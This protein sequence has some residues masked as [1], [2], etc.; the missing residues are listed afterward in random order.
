VGGQ[1]TPSA[2]TAKGPD[3]FA[4]TAVL[5][6]TIIRFTGFFALLSLSGSGISNF[7]VVALIGAFGTPLSAQSG[8]DGYLSAQA[9]D[10]LL[11]GFIADLPRRHAEV[12]ALGYAINACIVLAIGTMGLASCRWSWPCAAPG[13]SAA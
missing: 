5:T 7:A 11:G 12:A 13:C 3:H 4:L 6:P 8:A 9:L 10:V 1:G 2:T